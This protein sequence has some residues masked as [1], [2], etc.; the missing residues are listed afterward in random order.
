LQIAA[1]ADDGIFVKDSGLNSAS[2]TVKVQ[3]Q[4]SDS[5]GSQCF[6]GGIVLQRYNSGGKI[7][8][9]DTLGNIYF[10]GNHTDSSESNI[11]YAASI[12]A[13][14]DGDFNSVSDMPTAITF[15][16]GSTG[17]ALSTP[18]VGYGT[19]RMRIDSSGHVIIP[20]GVTLG[21]AAGT[22]NAANTIDDYEEGTFTPTL[23]SGTA[24]TQLGSYVKVGNVCHIFINIADFS[25]TTS[26]SVISITLPFKSKNGDNYQSTG[27]VMY[28][29]ADIINGSGLS[30]YLNDNSTL[31]QIFQNNTTGNWN[32]LRYNELNNALNAFR[33]QLTYFTD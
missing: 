20:N 29:Y 12:T 1:A 28:R 6:A 19:E 11:S 25:D 33:F 17:T 30:L 8:S 4:R 23:N 9:V 15:R 14:S 7:G 21:T 26:A 22:Y 31:L 5:N 27:P 16:T 2:P 10:G 3:G 24:T 18:N 32:Q 13:I